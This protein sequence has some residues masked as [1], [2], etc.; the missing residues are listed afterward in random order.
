MSYWQKLATILSVVVA[1][2][3]LGAGIWTIAVGVNDIQHNV[4]Y[5][6]DGMD[7]YQVIA[8][9]RYK[10]F[11]KNFDILTSGQMTLESNHSE[12]EGRV[13]KME[14]SMLS[15]VYVNSDH[16]RVITSDGQNVTI[17]TMPKVDNL[18]IQINDLSK[19]VGISQ[20][21]K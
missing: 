3:S 10:E 14:S 18:Q 17:P 8:T 11:E 2:I 13:G 15:V 16:I 7:A 20:I 21:A 9:Q 19:V 12:L 1:C 4:Q 6:K 5:T